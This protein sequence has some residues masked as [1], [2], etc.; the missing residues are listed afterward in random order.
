MFI[1]TMIKRSILLIILATLTGCASHSSRKLNKEW[2]Q[3]LRKDSFQNQF[4]GIMVFDP[5]TQDTLFKSNADKYFIPASNTKIFTFY[6]SLEYLPEKVPSLKY[7]YDQDTLYIRG[8][9]NP[10]FLHPDFSKQETLE[11]LN[12]FRYIKLSTDNFKEQSYGPGWAWD[13]YDYGY[14]A[15]RSSLP[16]YGNVVWLLPDHY[17]DFIPDV[18]PV[19]DSLPY[20]RRA[21]KENVYKVQNKRDDTLQIPFIP[22]T[23]AIAKILRKTISG[24]LI[25]KDQLFMETPEIFYDQSRD[26]I[27]KKMMLESDNFIAEQLLLM[28]AETVLDTMTTRKIIDH[29]LNNSLSGLKQKPRWVDGSGLSRYNLFTPE[30]MVYVL[31]QLYKK[32]SFEQLQKF[33]PAGGE[34]GTLKNNFK[35]STTPYIYAK[36][37]SLS[38]NYNLSGYL[39]TESGRVLIFSF[40]NNHYREAT[41]TVKYNMEQMFEYLRSNY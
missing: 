18:F 12:K 39:I 3:D 10:A 26:S 13:D 27:L 21:P 7:N 35:S 29:V 40:M 33:F 19:Y 24:E 37:G 1:L 14:S 5:E 11:F 25:M 6:T 9:G 36:S 20:S 17:P 4:T 32:Y 23:A 16:L 22:D 41:T 2:T 38:N 34:S 31:L 8:T 28:S 15:M 30:S